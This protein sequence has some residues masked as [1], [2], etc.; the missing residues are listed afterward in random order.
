MK[1]E[2]LFKSMDLNEITKEVPVDREELW[3][4][5]TFNMGNTEKKIRSVGTQKLS[6]NVLQESRSDQLYRKLLNEM[7]D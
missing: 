4:I 7:E 6:R 1:V 3:C 5:I 2:I